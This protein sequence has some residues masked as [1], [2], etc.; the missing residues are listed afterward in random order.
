MKRR[1]RYAPT[2]GLELKDVGTRPRKDDVLHR[3]NEQRAG[4]GLVRSPGCH[5]GM[6][7]DRQ[8]RTPTRIAEIDAKVPSTRL[9]DLPFEGDGE[10]QLVLTRRETP[11]VELVKDSVYVHT[12]IA[13]RFGVLADQSVEYSQ[14]AEC[15]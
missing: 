10:D 9:L 8:G 4:W 3:E 15:W 13:S 11:R 14:D 7:P 5:V 6:P 1:E 12:P 2:G